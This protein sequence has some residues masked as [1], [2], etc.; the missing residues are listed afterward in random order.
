MEPPTDG[1]GDGEV[2]DV[3]AVTEMRHQMEGAIA[4][5]RQSQQDL[6]A[7]LHSLVPDLASSLDVPLR[8]ISAFNRRPFSPTLIPSPSTE[9]SSDHHSVNP[10]RRHLPDT[11]TLPRTRRKPSPPSSGADGGASSGGDLLSVVRTMVAVCLLEFVPFTE[12]DSAALLRRLVNDQSS[13]TPSEKAALSDLGGDLG[14]IS[15]IEMA[16]RRIAEESGG[17]QLEEFTVN[18]KSV[19]MIWSI[20][21]NK[22]LKELP[23]SS[24]Q[25]QQPPLR[26]ISTE[27]NSSKGNY[28]AQGPNMAGVDNTSM[29]MASPSLDMWMGPPDAHLAGMPHLFPGSGGPP[30]LAGGGP[31]A[32]GLIGLAPLQRPLIGPGNTPGGPN[33]AMLKQGT[34]E[35]DLND[36]DALLN[37]KTFKE[38]QLSKAGEEL[39]E[40]I[41]R[42]TAKEAAA[43]A[44]FKTKGGSQLK[45]YCTHLTKEDC[46]RHSGSFVACDKVHF[47]RII[48]PHTDTNLGDCS[49]LDTCRHTKTCKYV[50]YELDQ[51]LDAPILGLANPPQRPIK[52]QRAEYC[53]EVELGQSQWI[54]CDIRTFRMDILGQFGVIMADPPW[55]IHMELPY[56]TMADEEMKNLNVPTLQTDGLIFLWVTGRAMELGRECLELWG[57]Q[58]VEEIIWVK[59]NQLQRIIRTGRT[60]HW[61]NHSK[62]HCLVGIKGNPEVNR[63]I[64]TDVIVAE[65]RETSRKPD[66]MYPMLERIS[67]RT[68][69]LE[70]FAR[71]H[72]THAGWLSLG[73]QLNGVQLVDEGLRARFKAAYPDVEVQ[74][75]SPTRTS[76]M[77]TD[78]NTSQHQP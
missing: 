21:R 27:R 28:Q 23:E 48:A 4:A 56:G 38:M 14:P 50:H 35:D 26:H 5:R 15:A 42:P 1:D 31:R 49:F 72:N 16:L 18:G 7:S 75:A 53:S 60:G 32:M 64:D 13:A 33:P 24:S 63:N 29:M 70:L 68:R 39:L 2:D 44:K 9:P 34:E 61:L 62:E 10:R 77:D 19:L 40:L 52:Y 67:P 47:R 46:R 69:K 30:S 43:A 45:E 36:L 57:Y 78:L 74:P 22:L 8:V 66:E 55:D 12:I 25:G 17:V 41:H 54:N 65:V 6:L 59:T 51:T 71:I 11:C 3:A 58:R 37:K 76:A 73:N 20:N